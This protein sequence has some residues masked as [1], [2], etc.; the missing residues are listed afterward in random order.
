MPSLVFADREGNITDF[1]D[2][3]MAGMANR[4]YR[5]PNL[6][7]LIPLPEGSEIFVLPGRLPVGCDIDTGEPLLLEDDPYEPGGTIQAVAAFM[8]PAHT[9]LL[10]SAYHTKDS[11][12]PTLPLFAY[13]AVGWYDDRFWVTGFRSD[14]D[15]RQD[16]NQY[17][18]AAVVKKTKRML[19]RHLDNRLIQHLGKCCL[20]YG[21]PA[22]RNYFLGRWEAPIPTSPHCNARCVGC[23][24]LQ[25]SGCC[26]STQ[27]RLQFVPSPKEISQMAVAHLT[28]APT[29]IVSF[30]QGC[31]GEP[32]LQ[33][34]TIEKAI[35]KIRKQ[36]PKGTINLNSN[37]SLPESVAK[38][39]KAGL[40]S[41]RVSLNSV[42]PHYYERYYRPKNYSF[43]DV[44]QS[45][46]EMKAAGKFVSLN[47]FILPGITDSEP[48]FEALVDFCSQLKVDFIQLRNLNMDPEWYLEVL[49][50]DKNVKP[51]GILN[52]YKKLQQK[53]P[54]LRFGYYNPY[55]Q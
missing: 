21:C 49:Q 43:E 13:C 36:T 30:G 35:I 32:L 27:E 42:Q 46:R 5:Q 17:S 1:P 39:A 18:Q 6:D 33:A 41:L 12:A 3:S 24:S 54:E 11:K 22:A 7:E 16:C 25:P 14:A 51:L 19:D 10:T 8:A 23:I 44:K 28:S 48:E 52:W 26:P 37:S 2:L 40:D 9:A 53:L 34:D 38:L 45:I 20:T 29:P 50:F 4:H 47:Y 15:V 31:E 55:L